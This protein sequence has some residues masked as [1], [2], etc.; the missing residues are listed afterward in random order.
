MASLICGRLDVFAP[1]Q[2][3][4]GAGDFSHFV[5][6]AGAKAH[7]FHG[8]LHED[9]AAVVELGVFFELRFAH[10]GIGHRLVFAEAFALQGDGA[11]DF[12][13][14]AADGQRPR[15][16]VVYDFLDPLEWMGAE[17]VPHLIEA[18]EGCKDD[19]REYY[20]ATLGKIGPAAKG[21]H[22]HPDEVCRA[23]DWKGNTSIAAAASDLADRGSTA[24][25]A[26][27][28]RDGGDF[29]VTRA[30]V[31]LGEIGPKAKDAVDA[32]KGAALRPTLG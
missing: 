26:T 7:F 15:A 5:E 2:V 20:I 25:F 11:G 13:A 10:G 16:E 9:V 30:A 17:A 12:F 18:V 28:L 8:L 21:A 27:L 1:F 24:G 19:K 3:G 6:G 22:P 31:E 23:N 4:D 14:S 29:V 32:R